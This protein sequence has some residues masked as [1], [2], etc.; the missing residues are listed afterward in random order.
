[1]FSQSGHPDR[2]FL[3]NPTENRLKRANTALIRQITALSTN[4]ICFPLV[5]IAPVTNH[6]TRKYTNIGTNWSLAKSSANLIPLSLQ[7]PNAARLGCPLLHVTYW[8]LRFA[9]ANGFFAVT[10]YAVKERTVLPPHQNCYWRLLSRELC[11][12]GQLCR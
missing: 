8:L 5:H 1:M 2:F 11:T 7:L 9:T 12:S 4:T 3:V 10:T 6:Y